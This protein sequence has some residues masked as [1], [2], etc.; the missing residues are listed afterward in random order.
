MTKTYWTNIFSHTTQK[1]WKI[2]LVLFI[3]TL[4]FIKE[5]NGK[6]KKSLSQRQELEVS[7]HS[8]LYLLVLV[9]VLVLV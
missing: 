4:L 9:L 3:G 5:P 1:Y 7:P 8:G 2:W 6:E